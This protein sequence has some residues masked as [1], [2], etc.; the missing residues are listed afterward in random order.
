MIKT[1][2]FPLLTKL[3]LA[4]VIITSIFIGL[5]IEKPWQRQPTVFYTPLLLPIETK[6]GDVIYFSDGTYLI[7]DRDKRINA[8]DHEGKKVTINS[9]VHVSLWEILTK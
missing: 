5:Q 1:I 8:I 3:L 6:K 2:Y 7:I 9:T 4:I